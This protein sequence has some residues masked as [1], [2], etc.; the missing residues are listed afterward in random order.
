MPAYLVQL[1]L[2]MRMLEGGHVFV[3]LENAASNAKYRHSLASPGS[4]PHGPSAYQ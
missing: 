1:A 2:V 3:S 4:L